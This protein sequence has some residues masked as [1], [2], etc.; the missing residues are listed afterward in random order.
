MKVLFVFV[1]AVLCAEAVRS[2]AAQVSGTTTTLKPWTQKVKDGLGKFF[3]GA[4]IISN[5]QQALHNR[6]GGHKTLPT[7]KAK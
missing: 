5:V 2:D 7:T 3:Q 1:L 4:A 6:H